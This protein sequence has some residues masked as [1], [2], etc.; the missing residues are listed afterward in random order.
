MVVALKRTY[1][2]TPEPKRVVALG[3]CGFVLMA[4]DGLERPS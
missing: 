1:D 3:D 2:A 4:T